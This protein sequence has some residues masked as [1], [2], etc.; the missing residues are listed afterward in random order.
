M[1][2]YKYGG[3]HLLSR[4]PIGRVAEFTSNVVRNSNAILSVATELVWIA[5]DAPNS[6]AP[7]RQLHAGHADSLLPVAGG[8]LHR[9][10]VSVIPSGGPVLAELRMPRA[11]AVTSNIRR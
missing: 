2:S 3:I 10:T 5:T 6:M 7:V 8:S 4:L 1:N 9:M 11:G